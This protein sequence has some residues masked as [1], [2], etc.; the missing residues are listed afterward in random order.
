MEICRTKA[1]LR[2]V[3]KDLGGRVGLVPTMGYLH[4][5]HLSLVAAASSECAHV[6]ATI[7]VN[8][9]QF[10]PN[11]DLDSY[12]RDTERDL[13]LLR[14]AGVAAVFLPEPGEMYADDAET[15]VETRALA[16]ILIGKLRPGH[17]Q[18]VATVVTKLFNIATPD[19][20]YFGQ[21]DYQQLCVIRRM[22]RDLDMPVEIR[23]MPI[24]RE[25]D[26]LA[27]SSRNVR[28]DPAHRAEAPALHAALGDG[29]AALRAGATVAE[30]EEAIRARLAEAP[31]G[32][33]R[34]VDIRDAAS[35]HEVAGVPGGPVVLLLAVAFG[36]VLLID[37]M[38]ADPESPT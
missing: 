17:F 28:L 4:D 26:G 2:A 13:N 7:F 12:P 32:E 1:H 15:V 38:V 35:L 27:M 18:G 23:G 5:G 20:A 10:G 14:Q 34:S 33:V 21:K 6:I 36:D 8:P 24:R 29:A 22:V 31:S 9:T 30:A 16:D 11:E 37:N 25:S 3:R 19:R